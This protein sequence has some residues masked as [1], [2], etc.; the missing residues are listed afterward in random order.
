LQVGA[1]VTSSRRQADE[2]DG[3]VDLQRRDGLADSFEAG[4][5]ILGNNLLELTA[6]RLS[7]AGVRRTTVVHEG[8]ALNKL[9]G[10]RSSKVTNPSS[11]WEQAVA[12]SLQR[13]IDL[14]LLIG[15]TAYIELDYAELVRFHL[16]RHAAMTQV[17][18]NS[19]SADIALISAAR[20][21]ETG[22]NMG[23]VGALRG[24]CERFNFRGYANR[25]R[26]PNDFMQL[27]EDALYRRCQ[28]RPAAREI[29][30]GLWIA[31]SAEVDDS[32]V[33]GAPSFV[34]AHSRVAACCNISGGS[35]VE[36]ACHIDSGTIIERSWV[37][38]NTYIGIGLN[39]RR[40]IVSKR[41]M[42]H[43]DRKTEIT[44]TDRRLVGSTHSLPLLRTGGRERV[45]TS[46][47]S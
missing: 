36:S 13:G 9:A 46:F 32:C 45:V 4:L 27:V 21:R 11:V 18:T 30:N 7:S 20:L 34:G 28:L 29:A 41:K 25:L 2:I 47:S 26:N 35:A 23:T 43:L 31:D 16:E 3:S 44:I 40:S 10:E 39:V 17:H 15:T 22:W 38:S 12:Q 19:G 6:A 24:E 37:L 14:L 33:I 1:I 8:L 42:F 5:T